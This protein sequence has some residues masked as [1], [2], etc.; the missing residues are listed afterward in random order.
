M[1]RT[2]SN[3]GRDR[4]SGRREPRGNEGA[5]WPA[6]RYGHPRRFLD[7]RRSLF[8]A[9]TAVPFENALGRP[10]I[11]SPHRRPRPRRVKIRRCGASAPE[12]AFSVAPTRANARGKPH[13][14]SRN[15]FES[16]SRGPKRPR[17][18]PAAPPSP[19]SRDA[20]DRPIETS[21]RRLHTR[22]S[23]RGRQ[24][25]SARRRRHRVL[26]GP[27]RGCLTRHP[28]RRR[29]GRRSPRTWG[30]PRTIGNI[31]SYKYQLADVECSRLF[32][33]HRSPGE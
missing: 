31:A 15:S 6:R 27:D 22:R 8:G 1:I 33:I 26:V 14:P 19:R 32:L 10:L 25:S 3:R 29:P 4:S 28:P 21:P 13:A 16:R 12:H 20:L 11:Q 5:G 7:G 9:T 30:G 2:G 17:T 23:R 24:R 18:S